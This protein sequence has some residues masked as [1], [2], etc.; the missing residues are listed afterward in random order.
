MTHKLLSAITISC[1]LVA[2]F[3]S[4]ILAQETP[5]ATTSSTTVTVPTGFSDDGVYGCTGATGYSVGREQA[6]GV[7]VPVSEN[8]VSHN[9]NILVYKECVLDGIANRMKESMIAFMVK[10]ALTAATEGADG[11]P[12]FVVNVGD[13]IESVQQEEFNQ[14]ITGDALDAVCAPSREAV[15]AALAESYATQTHH[16]ESA[17]ACSIPDDRLADVE[18]MV[19]G[20]IPYNNDLYRLATQPENTPI[21]QLLL[22]SL[23]VNG[24]LAEATD[25]ARTEWDWGNGYKSRKVCREVP[26]GNGKTEEYCEI[27]TPGHTVAALMDNISQTGLDA[28]K[29]AD[30]IDEL[31]GSLLSNLHTEILTSAGGLRG[32]TQ[33]INGLTSYLDRIAEDAAARTRTEYTDTG[34]AFLATTIA[35]ETTYKEA[36]ERSEGVLTETKETLVAK[37]NACWD[38]LIAQARADVLEIVVNSACARY[39]DEDACPITGTTEVEYIN[40]IDENN[41]DIYITA[42]AGN[43]EREVTLTHHRDNTASAI[44]RNITPIFDVVHQSIEST[45]QTLTALLILQSNLRNAN[46]SGNTRFILEQVDQMAASGVLHSQNDITQADTQHEQI[47]TTMTQVIDETTEEWEAG[48]CE[49]TNWREQIKE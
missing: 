18:A 17:Y 12:I 34:T 21:G 22:T 27:T 10:S 37:E 28:T 35:V 25:N 33:G 11:A 2:G 7:F 45:E 44:E 14:F 29:N 49:P 46:T 41:Y 6:L 23:H 3:P 30:E 42:Q 15:R 47:R 26:V 40:A 19:R 9:T 4:T 24:R 36:R 38:G 1:V 8:A 32:I 48:W 39:N 16:P 20:E 13:A 31:F 43:E 5:V